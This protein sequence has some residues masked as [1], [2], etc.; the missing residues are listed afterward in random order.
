MIKFIVYDDEV[1][2]R[3]IIKN[4]IDE[5]MNKLDIEYNIEEFDK[6]SNKMLKIIEDDSPKIYIMDIQVPNSLS[7][8][9][10]ARRVRLKDWNSIIILVTAF[11]DMGY[12]ALKAQIM[13]LD[14]ISKFN[15]CSNQLNRVIRKAVSKIDNK[16]VMIFESC[17]M[18][19]KIYTDDIIYI[20][21]DSVERKCI[22]KTDYNEIMVN[23]TITNLFNML[24]NRFFLSHRS[25]II[26]TDKVDMIDWKNNIIHFK[27]G[28]TIDYLAR[29]K[30]KEL[31]EYVRSN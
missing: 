12:E 20:L 29:D 13:L 24:D 6:Y 28:E 17:D 11:V 4:S 15:D 14:F 19:Y 10:V 21:K 3:N 5:I 8:I 22:I 26:N 1:E 9:D 30:K 18:T 23:Q 25:C 27:N 2:F 7:G 31:R 16:K